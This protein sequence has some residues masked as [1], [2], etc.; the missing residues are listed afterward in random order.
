MFLNR[1]QD[2]GVGTKSLNFRSFYSYEGQPNSSLLKPKGACLA[3][4]PDAV[5]E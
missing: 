4:C 1:I 5:V 3:L 2:V